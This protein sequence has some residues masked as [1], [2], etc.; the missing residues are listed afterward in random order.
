MVT[1]D[2]CT[3]DTL[4]Q[5]QT[6]GGDNIDVTSTDRTEEEVRSLEIDFTRRLAKSK[7]AAEAERAVEATK[8]VGVWKTTESYR[9]VSERG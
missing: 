8:G 5:E 3:P 2:Y 9:E 4:K 6:D 7:K 1:F